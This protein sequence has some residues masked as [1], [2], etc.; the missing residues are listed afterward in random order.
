MPKD[1]PS[2]FKKIEKPRATN[3]DLLPQSKPIIKTETIEKKEEVKKKIKVKEEEKI[4]KKVEKK[5]NVGAFV[6]PQKKPKT[7]RKKTASVKKSKFLSQKDF[8]RAKI[9]FSQI[10]S[11]KVITG[12]KTSEK[13][14]DKDFKLFVQWLYLMKSSNNATFSTLSLIHISEPTRPY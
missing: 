10:K 12:Y 1:K 4:V 6:L 5:I 3:K 11:G 2:V 13:I 14:K 7:I 8:E 9:A